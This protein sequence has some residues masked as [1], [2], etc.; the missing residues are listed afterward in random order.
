M[1]KCKGPGL[2]LYGIKSRGYEA[3]SLVKHV[4]SWREA[5]SMECTRCLASAL[6]NASW[7]I[8]RKLRALR[9]LAGGCLKQAETCS[10]QTHG[11]L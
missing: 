3:A 2:F 10:T 4:R 7:A 11:Q 8:L 6:H 9:C 1:A 5:C